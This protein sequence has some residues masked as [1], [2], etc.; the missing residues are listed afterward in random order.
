MASNGKYYFRTHIVTCIALQNTSNN[1]QKSINTY[2]NNK[3]HLFI[4]N[5]NVCSMGDKIHTRGSDAVDTNHENMPA[6]VNYIKTSTYRKTR[7]Q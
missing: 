5:K 2:N 4:V 6:V 3:I 7:L 1:I